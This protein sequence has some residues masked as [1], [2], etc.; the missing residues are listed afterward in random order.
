MDDEIIFWTR[1]NY[2]I[3]NFCLETTVDDTSTDDLFG[4]LN[5]E[6]IS[7]CVFF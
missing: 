4:I 2:A 6:G 1:L 7:L 3:S 5:G